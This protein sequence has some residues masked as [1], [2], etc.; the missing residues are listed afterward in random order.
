MRRLA[1]KIALVLASITSLVFYSSMAFA[2][3]VPGGNISY[4]CVGPN[5]YQ[6]TLTLYEDCGTA[7]EGNGAQF[8]SITNDCG[9]GGLT[10]TTLNNTIYQ[11][12][13]SQLCQPQLPNSECN[14]GTLPGVWMHQ[15][16]GIVTLPADCDSWVFSYSSC[17]RNTSINGLTQDS[18][19]WESVLNS[20]TAPC[21]N[22]AVITSQPIPYVCVNQVTSF[23]MGAVDPDGNTLVYS[24]IPAM[25]S[26]TTSI[27]YNGGYSGTAP[28]P[29]AVINS[30][31]GQVSFTA[32]TVGNYIFAVLVE[33]FDANGNL[34]GSII[35]DFQ[36][37]V[38]N[39]ANQ[40]TPQNPPGGIG[41]FTGDGVQTG[42]QSIQVCEGDSFC[43]SLTFTDADA[44]NILTLSTNLQQIFPGATMTTTGTNPL[45]VN[46]CHTIPSGAPATST[47]SFD[48][49][50]D[51]CPIPGITSFP[52][53]VNV[54]TSTYAGSDE[55]ICLGQGVQLNA[56][57][58]SNFNW[59]VVT[60]DPINVPGNFSCNG[61]GNPTVNP[62][63][64][65]TYLVT[66]NL[67]GGCDNTDT[68]TVNVVPNYT[69][70][71]TQSSGTSCLQDPVQLNVTPTPAGPGY[72][73]NWTPATY[74]S[75]TT[76]ANPTVTATAPGT[77]TYVVE[78]TSPNGC[79]KYDT[80]SIVVAAAYPPTV[81]AS[82]DQDTISCGDLV[83]L[84]VDLGGGIPATC[85]PSTSGG[86]S[87]AVTNITTGPQVGQ[88]DGYTWPAPYG[89]WYANAKHQFLY[90]AAE[91]NAMGFIGGKITEIRWQTTAQNGA[92][93][94]FV[95]YRISIGC[96][97]ATALNTTAWEGGL[98]QV[99]G[100][101]NYNVVL[102]SNNHVLSTPYEWDGVSN[103][104]VEICWDWTAQYSYTYNWSTP[105]STTAFVSSSFYYSDGTAAC[106]TT[107]AFGTSNNRP[108]TTFVT[109]PSVPDPLNY[110]Y[111]WSPGTTTP[112]AQN[113]T[114][115]PCF[116]TTYQIIVT[117]INGGCSDTSY[118]TVVTDQTCLPPTLD[119][120][121]VSCFGGSDGVITATMNGTTGPWTVN[122]Y[123][124]AGNVLLQTSNNV[125]S[126][127]S[128]INLPIGTYRVEIVDTVG[129]TA[130]STISIVQPT[131]VTVS[132]GA[133]TTICIGGTAT[134]TATAAGGHGPYTYNWDNGA[135][136][137]SI[138]DSPLTNQCYE[139]TVTDAN[140]CPAST[141]PDQ[142]VTL[143]PALSGST[144]G[145]QTICPG[146]TITI[147]AN[148]SGGNGGPY[149]YTWTENGNPF[150]TGQSLTATPPSDG[151]QYCVTISDNCGTPV[152]NECLTVTFSPVPVPSFTVDLPGACV[153]LTSTFTITTDPTLVADVL[154]DFGDGS[155][156]T[157]LTPVQHT[158][159]T[160]GCYDVTL[161][162]TTAIGCSA[163]TT[164]TDFVCAWPYPVA[165][166]LYGPQPTNIFNPTINFVNA[167]SA[168]VITWNYDFAGL[169]TSSVANPSFE[170]PG[171]NPGNYDVTLL[172]T[173]NYG[174]QD[175]VVHEVV[176][177]GI[178]TLYAPNAFTP[179]GDGKNDVFYILGEG[180]DPE[181]FEYFIFN[182]WGEVVFHASSMAVG[183]DG[184]HNNQPAKNDVYVWKIKSKDNWTKETFETYGHVTLIR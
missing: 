124:T 169:G 44:T 94:T 9:I 156:S 127:D 63:V 8:I 160:A 75:S 56:N 129:C 67:S 35:Q 29:G 58:G 87:G 96:T 107:A 34:V 125:T 172:V 33:E 17:C 131:Q 109:C 23:N 106:P 53:T 168:D 177:Q 165:E 43:F 84:T 27:S 176:I 72:T 16:T 181:E 144:N 45:T 150:G 66:S 159:T 78:V 115:T 142:C 108:I 133:D 161:T 155:T 64:T 70:N 140:G 102:G 48:V 82:A 143:N 148:A 145:N 162:V 30:S 11:Q 24:F 175:S 85:G 180:Y 174:C 92:Q 90:T 15:W 116:T 183:W 81:T 104:V 20:Q 98:T 21:N 46:V 137:A 182:R 153:P 25:T 83:N 57:G 173:N 132:T 77:Y 164:Y 13:V 38:I 49:E 171:D 111:Q 128:I 10:S 126:I 79:V 170:F 2:S 103:L 32:T 122:Y 73:Y 166:F 18:Y 76:T 4:E 110:S 121:S 6:I 50:D 163:D 51:A 117:D 5:Q 7:F 22:S 151:T 36:F 152:Y 14:G 95:N 154:W 37:E 149:T 26:A 178:Y 157:S 88:N 47:I 39:C 42:P 147:S 101:Q 139:V 135:T 74:L 60:G 41:N 12:E 141:T 134:L 136:G 61:C 130:S 118:V 179:D 167:S 55:I 54:I 158:Y 120:T 114:D 31:T 138:T 89:N 93:G 68:I 97:N 112:T 99:Y 146:E 3:H 65:T 59:T 113:T 100:P 62:A 119:T 86:C 184:T 69:F 40:A 123:N 105:Y 91:L 52:I 71:T 28:I 1:G 80:V 19:Y